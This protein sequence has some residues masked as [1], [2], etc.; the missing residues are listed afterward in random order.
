MILE[1]KLRNFMCHEVYN[2]Q[3]NQRLN[4]LC[5]EN[6]SGKSAVL[7]AIVFGLGGSAR[8]ANRGN[9]NKGFI[10]TGQTSAV[11]EIRLDNT[12]D[13]AYRSDLYGESITVVRSVTNSSCTYKLKDHRG[14]VV[15]DKK[16][17]EE[18]DRVLMSFNIQVD[19]PIAVLNQ[20]TAKTFLFKCD[21]DKLYTFFMRATQLEM[22]KADYNAAHVE[23]STAEGH[24]E[25]KK[26]SLPELKRELT[27]WEKK[28]EF[29]QN[30]NV[31]R[32]DVKKKKGELAWAVVRDAELEAVEV[33]KAA[34]DQGKKVP[35][36]QKKIEDQ[37]AKEKELRAN[38]KS[39]EAEIQAFGDVNAAL[40]RRAVELKAEMEAQ[41]KK[42]KLANSAQQELKR[43][44]EKYSR[45]VKELT[46]EITKRRATVSDFE[47]KS[48]ERK[49]QIDVLMKQVHALEA[50][51]STTNN[52]INHVRQN[53]KEADVAVHSA[54]GE[55][56]N[57]RGLVASSR[58]EVQAL[59][60][61]GNNRIAAFGAQMPN[62][63]EEIRKCRGFSKTPIGPL[64]A[65][66]NMVE[67]SDDKLAR[68]VEGELGGLVTSFLCDNSADQRILF[69]L[70]QKMQLR[71]IPPIFT[72]QFTDR[73]HNIGTGSKVQHE[74]HSTLIDCVDIA[75]ANVFNR[76]VDS[77]SLERVLFI[78][79]EAEAQGLLSS[80]N[81]V[82]RNLLHA[83][84]P[85]YQYYPAPNYRSY[86][87]QDQTR[88]VLKASMEEV[89]AKREE[90]LVSAL[91]SVTDA[92]ENVAEANAKRKRF[93]GKLKDEENQVRRVQD[94]VR[95][96]NAQ[97]MELRNEE[98]NEAPVDIAALED[99]LQV[100]TEEIERID[101]TLEK[102][103]AKVNEELEAVKAAKEAAD[104]AIE[105]YNDKTEGLGPLEAKLEE[106]EDGIRKASR[107]CGH[108]KTKMG[109]YKQKLAEA[110]AVAQGKRAEVE[111]A[112]VRA[113]EW[114]E[115][116][117]ESRK[118]VDSLKKE[119]VK[120][121]ES[122]K[123]QA[124]T[125]ESREVVTA[126]YR[127]LKEVFARADVQVK[128]MARTVEYL[129]GMLVRRKEGFGVIL[130]CTSRNV[131]RNFTTQLDAR[132]YL[133]TLDFD[134]KHHMLKI[135]VNPDSK[136]KAAALDIKRDIKSL[137]GG[138]KSYS[139]VS[140]ILALWNA[141]TPPFRVLDEFDVFMD[142]VN[143][144]ISLDN[145]ISNA[146]TDRKYQFI[147]L[148]P[149][150]TDGIEVGDDCKITKLSK[151][152]A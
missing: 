60:A 40:K 43:K 52:H 98:E 82:P 14:K 126:E 30:L 122:L 17:K 137:S 118:K 53:I 2:F 20:D 4:F 139:S 1:V 67:G 33:E 120:L 42:F 104:R 94:Q 77:C 149:L 125:Q 65:H 24:L 114:S 45:E 58:K 134:H 35:I 34:E 19:N 76:V 105:E 152:R 106:I 11:V 119:I 26:N 36:C 92:E 132:N 100:A 103:Q 143:R 66:I 7:A 95:R 97:I 116:K 59:K 127:R 109:E 70:F 124:E 117:V 108:Y 81:T 74:R 21:P 85:N 57:L 136:A 29:H 22:C 135:V 28:W 138:E 113:K 8:T 145:I 55:L 15:V 84:V 73:K 80:V 62:I 128:N 27:K 129:D 10:R 86:F 93:E 5:G 148:T 146:R 75:D 41:K 147:F 32:N 110:E 3:P 131:Q 48:R 111:A 99:D 90:Q 68:A 89:I 79:T 96:V 87:K 12:G 39:V 25:E 71:S 107:E 44:K 23:K 47:E 72:C 54:Q 123:R 151:R 50:Q 102:E 150:N 88:G 6:G 64:G 46:E 69:N 37:E 16:V 140:L 49:G 9:T 142:A 83:N 112:I 133:G 38:K 144:R 130:R 13:R 91:A 56:T 115:E 121:E 141:M 61:S 78:P 31:R 63:V 101:G 51:I 18:L